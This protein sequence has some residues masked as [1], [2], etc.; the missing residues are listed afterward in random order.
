MKDSKAKDLRQHSIEE[1]TALVEQERA[2]LYKTRH[3]FV[4]RKTTDTAGVKTR[5]HNLA[6][7]L[8]VISELKKGAANG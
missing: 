8:T 5:R 2:A 3:D 7:I 1:L 4:F 6:R